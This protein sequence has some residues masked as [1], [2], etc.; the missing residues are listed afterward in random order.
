M[1]IV[2][3][4]SSSRS[5]RNPIFPIA[6]IV[7]VLVVVVALYLLR[8][9]GSAQ[10]QA[11]PANVPTSVVPAGVLNVLDTP[12]FASDSPILSTNILTTSSVALTNAYVKTPG[13]MMLPD[14]RILTFEPPKAGSTKQVI[15]E[16][17]IYEC[18]AEGN[19]KDI[20]PPSAFDN[21]FENMLVGLSVADGNFIPG[22]LQGYD[23]EAVLAMLKKEVVINDDDC[24]D[25]KMKKQAVAEMKQIILEY[26]DRGGTFD[27]FVSEMAEYAQ[28]ERILKRKGIHRILTLIREGKVEEAKRFKAEI[29]S[30]LV[31]QEFSALRL[32]KP[33]QEALD[34]EVLPQNPQ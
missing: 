33:I 16:G 6:I 12:D 19:F 22:L 13:Q 1:P 8:E 2:T 26:I 31:E 25:I 28:Q 4:S 29:D 14:G 7:A 5:R 18:D 21:P 20:T 24:E 9:R 11:M 34:E 23:Q 15:A 32:P 10:P 30:L 3:T 17:K 27:Q